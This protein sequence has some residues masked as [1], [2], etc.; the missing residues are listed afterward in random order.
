MSLL[1]VRNSMSS[2][3]QKFIDIFSRTSTKKSYYLFYI[4]LTH[5]TKKHSH[6]LDSKYSQLKELL[7]VINKEKL[8][9]MANVQL[10]NVNKFITLF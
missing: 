3:E 10:K 1:L 6:H 7:T 8:L 5:L 2:H 4:L 9:K